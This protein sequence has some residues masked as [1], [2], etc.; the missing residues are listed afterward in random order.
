[1]SYNAV[2]TE[3]AIAQLGNL[4]ATVQSVV[5][6]RLFKLCESPTLLSRPS[7]PP[8]EIPGRQVYR[9]MAEP[10]GHKYWIVVY[11]QYFQNEQD[12]AI[13]DIGYVRYEPDDPW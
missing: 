4:P 10:E 12:L 9:F 5:R 11:F 7:R 8:S 13:M 2:I 3:T 1:M 6:E